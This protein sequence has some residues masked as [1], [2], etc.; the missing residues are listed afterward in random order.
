[1]A[2]L[3]YGFR[4]SRL[5]ELRKTQGLSR[6]LLAGMAGVSYSSCYSYE[7]GSRTPGVLALFSLASV[8]GVDPHD[9]IDDGASS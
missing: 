1:V 9:L 7:T 4:A 8:L 3:R 5:V 6:E 2:V